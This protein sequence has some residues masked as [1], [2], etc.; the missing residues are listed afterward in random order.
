MSRIKSL[1]NL[2]IVFLLLNCC[3]NTASIPKNKYSDLLS[4]FKNLRLLQ[5][6]IMKNGVPDYSA[7]AMAT[8]H[9]ELKELKNQLESID[10]SNWSISDRV[11]Y[12]LVK[13]ELVAFDFHHTVLKPWSR[14]PGFYSFRSG[15]AGASMNVREMMQPL[16]DFSVPLSKEQLKQF[17]A[18]FNI[19]PN[20]F[21]QAKINLT[22]SSYDLAELAIRNS[23]REA[24]M[25]LRIAEDLK[26]EHP[27]LS[28]SAQ[29]VSNEILDFRDWL[30]QSKHSMKQFA[31]SG[32]VDYSWWMHNVQFSPWG[33]EESNDIIQREYDRII[34]FL[35]FEENRNKNLP[36]LDVAMNRIDYETS[37]FNALN[38]VLNF[39]RDSE[40]MTIDDWVDPSDYSGFKTLKE[41]Q[42][43]IG[44]EEHSNDE[45]LSKNTS[46]DT[47]V[48]QRE[49]LPGEAHE[50]IG[51]M[52]DEQRQERLPLSP[53]RKAERRFN[54]GSMRLEG[55]AVA[56][57]ELLMQGGALDGRPQKGRE[58]EY[59]MNA[60]HM[61]LAIPDMKMHAN[62]INLEDARKLCADIMPRGWSRPE[63]NMV[64]FEMQSNLRNPGGFH[65]NVVTGKAYFMKLFRERAT[66]LGDKFTIKGFVDD[67]LSYGI[68]P[69]PLI[70]WEM[71]GYTDEMEA[72][73]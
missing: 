64:W 21:D 22:N 57:E 35:K 18:L 7:T 65:S 60:S 48:R 31:G 44:S 71:T 4:I 43:T 54:M 46:I 6:P 52:L 34:T 66:Q 8:Q 28:N 49:I 9:S 59:L 41:L 20:I 51:H 26:Y 37:L 58:M 69:M 55:W 12:H 47:K 39:L 38:H 15:D 29:L 23:K 36:P 3:T 45:F 61:S 53:I 5:N 30:I 2:F 24:E 11:D 19:V 27:Q 73:W 63:E 42:E 10:T 68:I 70:R 40:I 14:D 62:E 56:L 1:I 32:K 50:Y 33:W 25:F 16:H 67:F 13:G 72:H 17:K